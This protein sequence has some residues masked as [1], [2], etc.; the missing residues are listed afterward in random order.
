MNDKRADTVWK[1]TA[2]AK[3]FLEGTRGAIPLAAEQIDMM[4][5]LLVKTQPEL[6]AFM[7]IGCGDGILGAAVQARFPESSGVYI[8]FSDTMLNAACE[9]LEASGRAHEIISAD[10]KDHQWMDKVS[11]FAPFDA[12]I[13]GYAIHHQTTERKREIYGEIHDLLKPG[14][15]FLNIDNVSS[16]TEWLARLFEEDFVNRLYDYNKNRGAGKSREELWDEWSGRRA[17]DLEVTTPLDIQL[18]WLREI[19]YENVDCYIK[20]YELVMFGGWRTPL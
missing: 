4:L 1:Q 10:I 18:E 20:Y 12:V 7:D 6:K 2:Q 11:K 19:G 8:D 17:E 15:I 5:K 14:G 16:P 9:R 13:S 3:N